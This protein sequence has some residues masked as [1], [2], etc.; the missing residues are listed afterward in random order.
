MNVISPFSP[1]AVL[2]PI[3]IKTKEIKTIDKNILLI[4]FKLLFKDY[5]FT[6]SAGSVDFKNR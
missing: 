6:K 5:L 2:Q 3:S 4:I 1:S